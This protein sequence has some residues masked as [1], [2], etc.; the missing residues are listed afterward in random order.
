MGI[1]LDFREEQIVLVAKW[2]ADRLRETIKPVIQ[3]D[4]HL[5]TLAAKLQNRLAPSEEKVIV[6]EAALAELLRTYEI[7]SLCSAERCWGVIST[8][9]VE[10]VVDYNARGL[11][12]E[13]AKVAG[14]SDMAFPWK[15]T[16]VVRYDQVETLDADQN[17]KVIYETVAE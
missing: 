8:R 15:T 13:A 12:L 14:I 10:L 4:T 2:W 9:W 5:M 3:P 7:P 17:V 1:R 6:F 16:M 11:L